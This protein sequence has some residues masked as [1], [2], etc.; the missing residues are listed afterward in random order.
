MKAIFAI[1]KTACAV[2]KI[3]PENFQACKGF[4]SMT[5]AIPVQRSTN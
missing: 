5:S 4:E 2:V 3:K 1:M